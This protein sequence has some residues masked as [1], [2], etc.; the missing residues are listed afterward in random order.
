[1]EDALKHLYECER[2]G[3]PCTLESLAGALE[4]TRDAAARLLSRLQT[5]E[6]VVPRED[7]FGLTRAGRRSAI[8]VLR[9]HRLWEHYLA[10]RT[11]ADP[12]IW[13]SAA[14]RMEHELTD[15]QA[16]ELDHRLGRPLFDPHGDPIPSREGTLPPPRGVPLPSLEAGQSAEVTHVEDEPPELFETLVS[17]GFAPGLGVQVLETGDA[18]VRLRVAGRERSLDR[19]TASNV[20]VEPLPRG[21]VAG[22]LPRTLA[23]AA[24][25]ESVTVRGISPGCRGP[26]RRRLLDLGIVPGTSIVPELE[27]SVGDPVAYRIRGALIALRREQAAAIE[28]EP[29]PPAGDAE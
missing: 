23:D 3:A 14:D 26:R 10:Q 18:G 13:H 24:L 9:I 11:D 27:S 4:S 16:E 25:G 8:R 12:T 29:R 19:V 21:V 15:E 1:M 20:T 5:L 28:I 2:S 7:G 17:Q 6:L 22:Q